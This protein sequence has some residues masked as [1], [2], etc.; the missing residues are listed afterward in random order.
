MF[1]FNKIIT[2]VSSMILSTPKACAQTDHYEKA[3]QCWHSG[4][5]EEA[6]KEFTK[7]L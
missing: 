4:Q 7:A 3:L 6:L 2:M 5:N 1:N